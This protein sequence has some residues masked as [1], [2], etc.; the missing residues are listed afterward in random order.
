MITMAKRKYEFRPDKTQSGLLNKLYLTPSQRLNILR[1]T[2][3]GL[4]LL[5]LSV[6]QDVILCKASVFGATT[7][8][9]PCAIILICVELG[10][11]RG[12]LFALIAAMLYKFSGTAPGYY[13]IGLIPVLGC[14][15][16]VVRQSVFRKTVSST[17]LCACIA[18]VLY[19]L[20]IFG[21]GLLFQNT[22]SFRILRFLVT[23]GLSLL[24]YPILYP[25]TIAIEKIGEKTWKS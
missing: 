19:E 20:G 23:A 3:Y 6:V 13:V 12:C 5:I 15:F 8:L 16:A 18:V 17:M 1:W 24:S 10:A 2:L 21:F 7:D 22:A 14:L 4:I 9:V 11:D 25:I